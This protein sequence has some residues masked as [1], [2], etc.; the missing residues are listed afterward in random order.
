MHL[1]SNAVLS[2]TRWPYPRVLSS[3][4][5]Y[6]VFILARVLPYVREDPLHPDD[7]LGLILNT[8]ILDNKVKYLTVYPPDGAYKYRIVYNLERQ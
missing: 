3:F 5:D 1:T 2:F 7:P 6:F 4:L 8:L